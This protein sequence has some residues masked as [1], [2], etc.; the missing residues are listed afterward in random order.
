M[1]G[2]HGIAKWGGKTPLLCI[3][4]MPLYPHLDIEYSGCRSGKRGWQIELPSPT[5]TSHSV[6]PALPFCLILCTPHHEKPNRRECQN[7]VALKNTI[8]AESKCSGRP[9][10]AD[11]LTSNVKLI[12]MLKMRVSC[13]RR[14]FETL[15]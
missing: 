11:V 6:R 9:A 1:A 14:C 10:A 4:F 13:S 7:R 8:W 2:W 5:N 15:N 3:P 12:G